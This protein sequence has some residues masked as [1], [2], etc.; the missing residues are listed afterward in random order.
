VLYRLY[1]PGDFATLYAVEELC[2]QPPFR[3]RRAY[4]RRLVESRNSATWIAEENAHLIGFAIVEWELSEDAAYIQTVEVTPDRRGRGIGSELLRLVEDSA[5]AAGAP[6][7]WLHVDQE[8]SA[9]IRL[10]ESRGYI[11]QGREEHYYA[12]NRSALIYSRILNDS[13]V[14]P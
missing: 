12:R 7:I 1:Q 14:V 4:M 2:F 10:Y 3:F 13:R 11:L 5:R 6:S 9:A 8:N